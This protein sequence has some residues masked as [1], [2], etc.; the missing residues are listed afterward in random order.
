MEIMLPLSDAM[1]SSFANDFSIVVQSRREIYF[2]RTK[3]M[4]K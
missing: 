4:A 3:F 2:G 1:F